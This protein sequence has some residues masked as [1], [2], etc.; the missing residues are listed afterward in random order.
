M[1]S[2][3][4]K[5]RNTDRQSELLD[6]IKIEFV[7]GKSESMNDRQAYLREKLLM[8]SLEINYFLNFQNYKIDK[9]IK[10]FFEN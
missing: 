6:N 4:V 5:E 1:T 9:K 3:W 8:S 2:I 10:K 7:C